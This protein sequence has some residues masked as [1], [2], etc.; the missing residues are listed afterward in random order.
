MAI[1]AKPICLIK[2]LL[3]KNFKK[4]MGVILAKLNIFL[5]EKREVFLEYS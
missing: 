4:F 1:K 2:D 5:G 3:N